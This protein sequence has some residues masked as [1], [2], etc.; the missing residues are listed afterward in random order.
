MRLISQL[1]KGILRFLQKLLKYFNGT[2]ISTFFV[3]AAADLSVVFCL[4]LNEALLS[5]VEKLSIA[6]ASVKSGS[7][8]WYCH[9]LS[10]VFE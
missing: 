9:K 7:S 1:I 3:P 4:N 2:I 10:D 8:L 6:P 5:A